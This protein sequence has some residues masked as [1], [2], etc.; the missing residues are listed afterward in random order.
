MSKIA[1][2]MVEEMQGPLEVGQTFQPCSSPTATKAEAKEKLCGRFVC[3][4]EVVYFK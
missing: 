3:G 4:T 2:I 1:L